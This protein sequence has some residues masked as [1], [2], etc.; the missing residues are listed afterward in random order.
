MRIANRVAVSGVSLFL[1]LVAGSPALAATDPL[2]AI[3]A[4]APPAPAPIKPVTDTLYGVKVTDN[5][6]YME[7]L[8]PA[9]G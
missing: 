8:D 9:P 1:A 3:R 7:N 2:A 4:G 5:Y 6:R